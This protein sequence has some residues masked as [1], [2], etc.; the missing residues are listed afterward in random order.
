MLGYPNFS[1]MIRN[2]T[3]FMTTV[4]MVG[5]VGLS[6]NMI[7][8]AEA[9]KSK[10][11]PLLG[12]GSA[13][14]IC[15][16][17]MCSEYPGGKEAY[18][19]NWFKSYLRA[20]T[21]S[22]DSTPMH[23]DDHTK[24]HSDHSKGKIMTSARTADSEYPAQLDVFIHKFE[25]DKISADE[26][27]DGIQEIHSAYVD[28]RITTDI[29]KGVGEKLSLYKQG[30]LNAEDAIES[31]HLTAEPQNVNPEYQG[32]LDEV[33]HLFEKDEM[34]AEDAIDG[35]KEVHNG[36][37]ALYITS[38][39]IEAV[40][41]T[42]GLIDSGKLSGSD[43][44]EA[45]HL[46][47]EPQNVNPEFIGAIDEHLHKYELDNMPAED[48]MTGVIEVHEGFT[49]LY[50]T[51]E[52]IDD[53]G[54]Q[55]NIH[56]S[57]NDSVEHVLHEIH[58]IIEEHEMAA[59]QSVD[60]EIPVLDLPLNHVGMPR[61][62]GVPGCEVDN[63]C[64]LQ[65]DLHVHVGDTVTWVNS[66]TLPHTVTSVNPTGAEKPSSDD[67]DGLFDSGFMSGGDEWSFTF[68]TEGEYYY[69]CQ[70]HPWMEGSVSV[71]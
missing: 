47:A 11:T 50:V 4:L 60:G 48:A 58:E 14:Q 16:L 42:I 68:D 57:G 20:P 17:V 39:L 35:I 28:A 15:G 1:M 9:I 65:A 26:A 31:V 66:D 29:I 34:S 5:V 51:S 3:V 61:G 30:T 24:D 62:S 43:A 19:A 71:A 55:I 44:V 64:Y 21:V 54:I 8:E 12:T 2:L 46:T 40:D 70:L 45:V 38:D 10:G 36:F 33:I 27:L 7:P 6:G 22:V 41:D 13:S 37:V 18:Q 63:W 53:I 56:N 32:A 69:Y 23:S 25:M 67:E 59:M 49:S 52:L